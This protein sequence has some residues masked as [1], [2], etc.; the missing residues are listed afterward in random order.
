MLHYVD[1][2]DVE[3][4]YQLRE[5]ERDSVSLEDMQK[6]VVGVEENLLIKREEMKD[7]RRG[8]VKGDPF[9][10]YGHKLDALVKTMES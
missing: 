1:A 9:L 6:N 7:E 4:T 2:F 5:R 10:S 3:M 8:V